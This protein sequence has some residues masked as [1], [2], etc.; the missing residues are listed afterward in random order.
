M[1]AQ[2]NNN[3]IIILRVNH[4]AKITTSACLAIESVHSFFNGPLNYN[5]HCMR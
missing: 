3:I 2:I 1:I 5:H 4:V